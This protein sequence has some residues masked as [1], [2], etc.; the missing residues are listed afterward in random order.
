MLVFINY[1]ITPIF[2]GK[3]VGFRDCL[4]LE[5]GTD[6]LRRNVGNRLQ[7]RLRNFPAWGRLRVIGSV[8]LRVIGSVNL[9]VH[10]I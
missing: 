6:T 2:K 8:N 7:T 4:N 5:S 10:R 9:R 1:C 3:A